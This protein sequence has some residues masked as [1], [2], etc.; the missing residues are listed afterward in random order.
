MGALKLT[1]ITLGILLI[2]RAQLPVL[3]VAWEHA[4]DCFYVMELYALR[5]LLLYYNKHETYM[6]FH[7][8]LSFIPRG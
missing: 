8:V 2:L 7:Q 3:M 5:C 4:V 6:R 1:L